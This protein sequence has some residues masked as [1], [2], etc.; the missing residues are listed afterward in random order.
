MQLAFSKWSMSI[1]PTYL[2]ASFQV[3]GFRVHFWWDYWDLLLWMRTFLI[4]LLSWSG[5][6]NVARSFKVLLKLRLTKHIFG[7]WTKGGRKPYQV[8]SLYSDSWNLPAIVNV[9]PVLLLAVTVTDGMTICKNLNA[10]PPNICRQLTGK[11]T[12]SENVASIQ[13]AALPNSHRSMEN[14]QTNALC[15]DHLYG[16]CLFLIYK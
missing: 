13:D 7:G 16:L 15:S 4:V 11:G 10:V 8:M 14:F 12:V 5:N 1:E 9:L 2:R 3:L 6:R